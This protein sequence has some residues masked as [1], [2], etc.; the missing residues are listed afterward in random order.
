MNF[1]TGTFMAKVRGGAIEFPPPIRR[2]CDGNQWTLFRVV[3]LDEDRLEIQPVLP[4]DNSDFD[5]GYQ[6]TLSSLSPDGRLWIPVALRELISL[7]E[8]S[9]MMRVEE[10][11][12]RIYLR[13]VFKTL[14]FGP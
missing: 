4:D 2:F 6:A 5:N 1:P 7:G 11:V 13:N 8:Q 12:I 10:D 14:G 3:L 9:V